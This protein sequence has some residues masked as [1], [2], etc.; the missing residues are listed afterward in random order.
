[1]H[2]SQ[3]FQ[4]A[5]NLS[6]TLFVFSG[7]KK[8]SKSIISIFHVL[9]LESMVKSS[10]KFFTTKYIVQMCWVNLSGSHIHK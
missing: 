9:I 10:L 3:L 4:K 2:I 6:S 5:A 7:T 8:N 1:M